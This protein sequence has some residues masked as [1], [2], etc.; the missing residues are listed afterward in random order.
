MCS[1]LTMLYGVTRSGFRP[2]QL[3]RASVYLDSGGLEA[4]SIEYMPTM[5][6]TPLGVAANRAL[7]ASSRSLPVPAFVIPASSSTR[8]V[9]NMPS[10]PSSI[11]WLL[12]VVMIRMPIPLRSLTSLSSSSG[13]SMFA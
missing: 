4:E 1:A 6:T 13:P 10:T 11:V 3:G 9:W 7:R 12:A 5:P 2:G 8:M